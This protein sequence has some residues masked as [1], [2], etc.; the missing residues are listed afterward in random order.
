MCFSHRL[1]CKIKS[2]R[3]QTQIK[4]L[5]IPMVGYF[6]LINPSKWYHV[7]KN[8]TIHLRDMKYGRYKLNTLNPDECFLG[9]ERT[10]F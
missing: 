2:E 9:I 1:Q 7:Y 5:K 10:K 4:I 8:P 3:N 6:Y